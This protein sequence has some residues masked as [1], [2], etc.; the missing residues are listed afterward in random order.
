MIPMTVRPA[1][2]SV[3]RIIYRAVGL[4]CFVSLTKNVCLLLS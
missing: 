3:I 1:M 2:S 4:K